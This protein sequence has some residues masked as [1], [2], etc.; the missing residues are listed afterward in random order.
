[1]SAVVIQFPSRPIRN[2]LRSHRARGV[3]E[4]CHGWRV[5]LTDYSCYRLGKWCDD[6]GPTLAG[7]VKKALL[8]EPLT[9]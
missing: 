2:P 1:M 7:M 5:E 8:G 3:C 9:T 4:W 6:C